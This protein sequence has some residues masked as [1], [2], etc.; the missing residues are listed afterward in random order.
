LV[1]L[2]LCLAACGSCGACEDGPPS[3]LRVEGEH[4]YTRCLAASPPS[5]ATWT[6]GG[7]ELALEDAVLTVSGLT[8]PVRFA[9]FAGPAPA[10]IDA[11][12]L[13]EV[14]GGAAELAI[15]LGGFGDAD[16]DAR[17]TFTALAALSIPVLLVPGGRDDAAVYAPALDALDGEARARLVDAA[18]LERVVIGAHELVPL[19]GAPM[20]RHA[21]TPTACGFGAED[22]DARAEALGARGEGIH[23]WLVAWAAP[24]GAGATGLVGVDAGDPALARFAE[25]IGAEGG[26]Y[27][28]PREAA[29]P[30]ATERRTTEIVRPVSGFS[31]VRADGVRLLPGPTLRTLDSSGF[32]PP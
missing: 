22:L 26:L 21:R 31:V 19:A 30:P 16:E 5:G 24:H 1:A 28:W 15:V 27:A 2:S 7:A 9:V 13:A 14:T 20:G 6:A 11:A 4:P 29:T 25:R 8:E 32:S 10:E 23:R 3:S 17:A 12:A 18:P